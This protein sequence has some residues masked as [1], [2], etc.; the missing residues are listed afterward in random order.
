MAKFDEDA[1]LFI[2]GP[3]SQSA[4]NKLQEAVKIVIYWTKKAHQAK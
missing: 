2:T 1:A 3:D 4:T